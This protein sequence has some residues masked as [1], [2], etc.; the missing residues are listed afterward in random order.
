MK[1]LIIT[2]LFPNNVQPERGIFNKQQFLELAKL[3][4]IRVVAPVPWFPKIKAGGARGEFARVV[5]EE[6]IDGITTYHPR[7]IV[8]PKFG[9]C[10]YGFWFYQGICKKV[11]E[12]VRDFQCDVILATW[13]YP[14]AFAAALIARKLR[15]PLV[16]KVHGSD[17]NITAQYFWRRKM[18]Q[19]GLRNAEKVIAVTESLKQKIIQLGIPAEKVVVIPNGVDTGLF[20][21]MNQQECRNKLALP[22]DK[23]IVLCIGNLTWV[24]GIK[25]L[26]DAFRYLPTDVR[27]YIIGQGPLRGELEQRSQEL[28]LDDRISFVGRKSHSEIPL[29]MNA[30]DVLCLPSLNEG[31]PNVVLE[32][33]ACGRFVVASKVGGIPQLINSEEQGILV[34]PKNP[35]LL[36]QTLNLALSKRHDAERINKEAEGMSWQ[37]N[38]RKLRQALDSASILIPY[39]TSLGERGIKGRLKS[40]FIFLI[41]SR[42]ILWKLKWGQKKIALTFDDGPNPQFTPRFLDILKEKGIKATFFLT[43]KNME[44]HRDLTERIIREGHCVGLHSYSHRNYYRINLK[45]K[46][47]EVM[48]T[49]DVFKSITGNNCSLFRP[50]HGAVSLKQ[51]AYC[52]LKGITMVLWSVDSRDFLHRGQEDIINNTIGQRIKPGD[53][54]L[55]HDDN[56]FT[57]EALPIIIEK[58]KSE[59]LNFVTIDSFFNNKTR[60][61]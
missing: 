51:L 45:D 57:L 27:L 24:K 37:E 49:R 11:K 8:T 54:I 22:L 40:F 31:C 52:I 56:V 5:A 23:K 47:Y 58:L 20:K 61:C 55:F 50:P 3:C 19:Y 28:H 6:V 41:P 48:K 46:I 1:V 12:I 59:G 21:P 7:Y 34:E 13:A 44:Q 18:I 32:A 25:Y 39:Q 14:D 15:K 35:Q 29:W 36:T 4:Q 43:G 9:R 10:F 42:I 33:L 53:I 17:I 16:I 60:K 2:N 26:I 38:A 30:S